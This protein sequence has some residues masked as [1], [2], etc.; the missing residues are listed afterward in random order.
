MIAR[1]PKLGKRAARLSR[2]TLPIGRYF[3]AGLPPAPLSVDW[4]PPIGSVV[5]SYRNDEIGICAFASVAHW[6]TT[7]AGNNGR[8]VFPSQADV[9]REYSIVGGYD[10]D[11]RR[12]WDNGADMATVGERWLRQGIAGHRI[13]GLVRLDHDNIEQLRIAAWLFGPLWV[14]ASL[15]RRA[16]QQ[17]SRW[18]SIRQ[19]FRIATI[20]GVGTWG[21]HAMIAP[22]LDGRGGSFYTWGR[23]Q[24]FD[25]AWFLEY[26]DEAYAAVSFDWLTDGYAP[27]GLDLPR[28]MR[29]LRVIGEFT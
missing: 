21:G 18:S 19:S 26:V 9:E 6:I 13:A 8:C 14:G 17:I 28:L 12:T 2:A 24:P 29:D 23:E 20:D 16:Q 27:N 25:W 22:R 15:P 1:P 5:P 7:V 11:D 4:T 10:P 3:K